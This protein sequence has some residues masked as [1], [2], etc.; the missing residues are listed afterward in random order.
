MISGTWYHFLH[1][2]TIERLKSTART[3][4]PNLSTDID[5]LLILGKD[6]SGASSSVLLKNARLT[7]VSVP[8]FCCKTIANSDY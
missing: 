5:R 2:P 7:P 4:P 6:P 8:F 3:Q 1:F